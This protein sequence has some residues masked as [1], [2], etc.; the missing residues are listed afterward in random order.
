MTIRK[1]NET[2]PTFPRV[3]RSYAETFAGAELYDR[4]TA[5][6][7]TTDALAPER[8]ALEVGCSRHR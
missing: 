3:E 1:I 8:M 5:V 4:Q 6:F 7:L 2:K